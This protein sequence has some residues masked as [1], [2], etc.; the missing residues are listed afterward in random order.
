MGGPGSTNVSLLGEPVLHFQDNHQLSMMS[1]LRSLL[2]L[3]ITEYL[4]LF[5][6]HIVGKPI[7]HYVPYLCHPLSSKYLRFVI[8][9]LHQYGDEKKV[10]RKN[11][12]TLIKK[13][14]EFKLTGVTMIKPSY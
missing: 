5:I 9:V 14:I 3:F 8:L 1:N 4:P 10:H 6:R 11:I 7:L 13:R 2:N 12:Q